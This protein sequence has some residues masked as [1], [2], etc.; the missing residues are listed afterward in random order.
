MIPPP[1]RGVGMTAKTY[2][3]SKSHTLRAKS[4]GVL[5]V[6]A[7]VGLQLLQMRAGRLPRLAGAAFLSGTRIAQVRQGGLTLAPDADQLGTNSNGNFFGRRGAD[8]Q[9][10]WRINSLQS[11]R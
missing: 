10:D 2:N 8:I 5:V 1:L 7:F 11:L 6:R 4:R 3:F 9:S